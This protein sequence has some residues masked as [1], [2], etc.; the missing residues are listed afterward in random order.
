MA[1]LILFPDAMGAKKVLRVDSV[2]AFLSLFST[3]I[4]YKLLA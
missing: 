3:F 4:D 1:T 2:A